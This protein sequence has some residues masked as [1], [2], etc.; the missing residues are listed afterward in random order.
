MPIEFTGTTAI[1]TEAIGIADADAL[2][3]WL[4][5]TP[6]PALNLASCHYLHSANLQMLMAARP[7]ILAWPGNPE[8]RAWL[9]TAF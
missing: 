3:D 4:Q 6:A 1:L 7:E 9:E 2:F 5:K 8:L